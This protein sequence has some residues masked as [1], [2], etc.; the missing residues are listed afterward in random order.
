MSATQ[1]KSGKPWSGANRIPNI[2]EFVERLDKDKADRDKDIDANQPDDQ[3]TEYN[4]EVQPHKNEKPKKGGKSV[5]DPVTGNQVVIAN[6][7]KEYM[8]RADNPHVRHPG[9]SNLATC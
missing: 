2:K 1:Q 5:T 6:V 8:K 4:S 9:I 7:G 3:L